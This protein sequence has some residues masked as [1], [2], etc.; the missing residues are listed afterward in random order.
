MFILGRTIDNILDE[1]KI[2]PNEHPCPKCGKIFEYS[3]YFYKKGYIC[4]TTDSHECFKTIEST[5]P[6]RSIPITKEK[7]EFWLDIKA[8][9]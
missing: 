3:Q 7:I 8:K 9:L 6:R 4:I 1:Y 2:K 5:I